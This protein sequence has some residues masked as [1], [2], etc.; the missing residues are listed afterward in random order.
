MEPNLLS[1]AL[2]LTSGP[3]GANTDKAPESIL[4][5]SEEGFRSLIHS[6]LEEK[7]L[8]PDEKPA[9]TSLVTMIGYWISSSSDPAP[10]MP[11][12]TVTEGQNA[13]LPGSI[14]MVGLELSSGIQGLLQAGVESQP[15]G[16]ADANT[17]FSDSSNAT[18]PS[19]PLML[20]GS[21]SIEESSSDKGL[22]ILGQGS[23]PFPADFSNPPV[24]DVRSISARLGIETEANIVHPDLLNLMGARSVDFKETPLKAGFPA[25]EDRPD[26]LPPDRLY[27]I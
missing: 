12:E 22:P 10:N 19:D 9:V 18:T 16:E 8:R 25:S 13:P 2:P 5:S 14:E 27:Y 20:K 26:L 7:N 4:L 15:F 23:D 24:M 21:L 17:V 11:G 3:P 6:A 1:A